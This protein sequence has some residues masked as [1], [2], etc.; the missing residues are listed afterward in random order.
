MLRHLS[1]HTIVLGGVNADFFSLANGTPT[2][3]LIVDGRRFTPPSRAAVLAV[4]SAGVVRIGPF[5]LVGPT[6]MPYYPRDAVGGRP[7]IIR[8]SAIVPGIDTASGAVFSTTRHPRTAAGIS[9]D[10]RRLLLAVVDGRQTPFSD[11]MTLRELATLMLSLG[12]HTALNLDG[13]GSSTQLVA[14]PGAGGALR[15][16]N[17]PSD[18][19]GER[20]VGDAVALVRTCVP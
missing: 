17:R 6:L 14:D 7:I 11:G 8:D 15:I 4:D 13:G 10:G 9:R 19:E 18:K 20:P 12:A 1:A 5:T 3:L 16:A 2:G